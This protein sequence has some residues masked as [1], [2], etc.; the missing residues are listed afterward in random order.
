MIL[1]NGATF[2]VRSLPRVAKVNDFLMF[3]MYGYFILKNEG[4]ESCP[5]DG[6]ARRQLLHLAWPH[7]Q[8]VRPGSPDGGEALPLL[9]WEK[10]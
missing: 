2:E 9:K 8:R 1:P 10:V 4:T 3:E 5:T 7:L 6:E